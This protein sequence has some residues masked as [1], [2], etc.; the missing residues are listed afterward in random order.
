MQDIGKLILRLGFGGF[1]LTHGW[2]KMMKLFAG[3]EIQWAD[4]IG[5]GPT[6]S[7][8]LA[9][10]AEVICAILLIVG[11]KSKWATIPLIITMLVAAFI[12]HA[13]DPWG[14][15]EFALLYALGYL[16]IAFL[17][18]GKYSLDGKFGKFQV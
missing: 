6:I 16:A 14:K 11:Y 4:P 5:L 2:P 15:K 12:V 9:V 13:D 18:S 3:G 17:G 8:I 1:M 10:F 7:L